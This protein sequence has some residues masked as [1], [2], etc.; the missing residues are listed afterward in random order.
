MIPFT[1]PVVAKNQSSY[2]EIV[3]RDGRPWGGG[4][5][6]DQALRVLLNV[7]G[8]P[9]GLLTQSCTASLELAAIS[10]QLGPGDEVIV[11]SY[12]FVSSANAFALRGAKIVF[13]DVDPYSLNLT[14]TAVRSAITPRTKVIVVVHYGGV[15][16]PIVEIVDI[17]KEH[18]LFVVED[19]AQ[20]IG[21]EVNGRPL[22][23]IG[24]IGC[25]SFHGTKNLS[26]GE[27]GAIVFRG[28]NEAIIR[29]AQIAHEKGT[30][31]RAFLEGTV[32]KYTWRELGSSFIPSEFT[33][34]IMLSQL[35]EV[36]EITSR[37]QSYWSTYQSTLS[38]AT[39]GVAIVSESQ[40]GAN[41]HMFAVLM[42]DEL[43]RSLVQAEMQALGVQCTAHYTPLHSS[44][45]GNQFS[46][47]TNI[48]LSVTSQSANTIL[49]LPMWSEQ[50]LDVSLI[51]EKFMSALES[52]RAAK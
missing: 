31:R 24:D 14:A 47:G 15:P 10:L 39:E 18:G 32:D 37:R 21:S 45:F 48:D 35:E 40:M 43:E 33:A 16:A 6:Y 20:A 1:R 12:T 51:A 29:R 41:G 8:A 4:V 19:A 46:N 23:T 52:A 2:L 11:P 36:A 27:G 42:R 9:S 26:S 49:R 34:A 7:T 38:G 30:D 13:V 28:D 5:F 3:M 50:G 17:A 25:F 22:G 44:P